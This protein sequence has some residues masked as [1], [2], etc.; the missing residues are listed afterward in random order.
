MSKK[1]N[2]KVLRIKEKTTYVI[3]MLSAIVGVCLA[4]V[5]GMCVPVKHYMDTVVYADTI[6][7]KNVDTRVRH[8]EDENGQSLEKLT[9][10]KPDIKI[11][12][13]DEIEEVNPFELE[14]L[15]EF[16]L[17]AYCPCSKCC[18]QYASSPV[19]KTTALGVGCYGDITIAV[20]P[21]VI[22]YGTKVYIEDIGVRIA[23]DCGG[24]IKGNRIDVYYP[25]HQEALDTN[26]AFTSK[27]VYVI[28]ENNE[29]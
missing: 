11:E 9:K 14:S 13:V 8:I 27:K 28:K 24:A 7:E 1:N 6:Q 26:L 3:L 22:P 19:N 12:V 18:D 4:I 25:T 15:G 16:V 17:T 2:V 5:M 23:T 21:K 20:D 10:I 29:K